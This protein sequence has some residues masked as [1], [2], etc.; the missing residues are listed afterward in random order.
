M[1]CWYTSADAERAQFGKGIY[2]PLPVQS[3]EALTC[4]QFLR[5]REMAT[6]ENNICIRF[7]I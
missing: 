5:E 6:H 4:Y 2:M 1:D 7:L 3:A